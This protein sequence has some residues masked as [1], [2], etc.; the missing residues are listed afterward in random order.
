MSPMKSYLKEM[1]FQYVPISRDMRIAYVKKPIH[2]EI[3]TTPFS[4]A[5]RSTS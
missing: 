3:S 1:N 4:D 2:V 5:I